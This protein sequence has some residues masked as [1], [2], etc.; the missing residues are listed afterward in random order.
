MRVS[1][2][3]AGFTLIEA[4]M[5]IMILGVL[6]GALATAVIL[7][8]RTTDQTTQK[9]SESPGLQLASD[10]FSSDVAA[11]DTALG[12]QSCRLSGQTALVSFRWQDPGTGATTSNDDRNFVVSYVVVAVGTQKE[13]QRNQC[14][15][16]VGIAADVPAS[17]TSAVH[18]VRYV[19]PTTSPT[20]SSVTG[21]TKID[22][23]LCTSDGAKCKDDQVSLSLIGTRRKP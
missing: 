16:A 9:L 13:L 22:M 23:L 12:A 10:Y 3:E 20:T 21:G 7:Y 1:R 2:D 11:N 19:D 6:M 17:P 15:G 4:L 8:F 18:L 14:I 5:S